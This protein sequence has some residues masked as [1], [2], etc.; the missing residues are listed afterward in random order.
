ALKLFTEGLQLSRKEGNLEGIVLSFVG[1][2]GV[3]SAQQRL[4]P[5]VRLFG[6]AE[7]LINTFSVY[8][9]TFERAQWDGDVADVRTQLDEPTLVAAWAAGRA[10]TL[11]QA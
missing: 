7:A 1:L 10:L 8:L 5:A 4:E 3:M 6:V 11:E 2:A 9:D